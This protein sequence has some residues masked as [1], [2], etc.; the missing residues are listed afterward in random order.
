M[1]DIYEVPRLAE[2]PHKVWAHID[3]CPLYV[4][5]H[6]IRPGADRHI[7]CIRDPEMACDVAKG[8]IQFSARLAKIRELD[9]VMVG[10]C[11]FRLAVEESKMRLGLPRDFVGFFNG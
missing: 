9:P 4:E 7:G 5:S 11:E 10:Q 2:C 6:I 3:F 8:R 1:A